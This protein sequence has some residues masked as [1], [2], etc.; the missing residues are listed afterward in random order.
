M[1]NIIRVT[2]EHMSNWKMQQT[3]GMKKPPVQR[4]VEWMEQQQQI[5]K[6]IYFSTC[7]QLIN[8]LVRLAFAG[9]SSL[10]IGKW[11]KRH[12]HLNKRQKP[13]FHVHFMHKYALSMCAST[14]SSLIY[15]WSRAIHFDESSWNINSM[16]ATYQNKKKNKNIIQFVNRFALFTRN[17]IVAINRLDRLVIVCVKFLALLHLF[18]ILWRIVVVVVGSSLPIINCYH[19]VTVLLWANVV[20]LPLVKLPLPSICSS[21]SMP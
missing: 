4:D 8:V 17:L 21:Y 6:A 12:T 10:C 3:K 19:I 5:L 13:R 16:N 7:D 2:F 15:Q 9:F 1:P 18:V 11:W 20:M 14:V